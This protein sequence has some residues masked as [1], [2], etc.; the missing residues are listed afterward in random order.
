MTTVVGSALA[1]RSIKPAPGGRKVKL[2][3]PSSTLE[4][5]IDG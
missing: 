4:L 5:E 1:L 3:A 2:P